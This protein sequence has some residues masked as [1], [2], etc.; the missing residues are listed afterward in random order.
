MSLFRATNIISFVS[1]TMM[2][3]T[4]PQCFSVDCEVWRSG[5]ECFALCVWATQGE[6][7]MPEFHRCTSKTFSLVVRCI[8]HSVKTF[9][10]TS[11]FLL[12]NFLQCCKSVRIYGN[13]GL[14]GLLHQ[15]DEQHWFVRY[16]A[17]DIHYTLSTVCFQL[18]FQEKAIHRKIATLWNKI[19]IQK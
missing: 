7:M 10:L 8:H 2:I 5:V 15:S 1:S 12:G 13:T 16:L 14:T 3:Y 6:E 9:R 19:N 18:I 11:P 17:T 4:A